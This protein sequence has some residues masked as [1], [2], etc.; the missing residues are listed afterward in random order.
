MKILYIGCYRDHTG[1]GQAAIDYILAMDSVGIDVVCRPL[2]LNQSFEELPHRILELESKDSSGCNICI[3]HILPH[4]MDYNGRLEKNI[5]L[6]ATET[7][8]FKFSAWPQRINTLDEAWVINNP[9]TPASLESGINIPIKVIPHASNV[10]KF[11][12]KYNPLDAPELLNNF[13]F[14]FIGD[15]TLRKNLPALLKAFHLEFGTNENVELLIKTSQYGLGPDQCAEKVRDICTQVKK[16]LKLYDSLENYK[17]ELI[18]TDRLSEEE[19][20]RLHTSCDCFVMPSYGEAWCIPAFD[21]LGFGKTPICTDVGGMADFLKNKGASL[22]PGVSEPVFGMTDT[23]DDIYT[24][25]E[26]WTRIDIRKLQSEMRRVYE[27]YKSDE[28]SYAELQKAGV[29]AAKEFSYEKVGQIIK[30]ELENAS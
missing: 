27:T 2:K 24:G 28:E 8:N 6:Y 17:E 12:K 10:R 13:V 4:Y 16:N 11:D 3:Q 21:A 7:S 18:V 1:W 25:Q 23:F 20:Y 26:D 14:Y 30:D 15:L 29:E 5:A 9:S 22:V 19:V